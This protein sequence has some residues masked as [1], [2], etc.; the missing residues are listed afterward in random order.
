MARKR[1]DA[2]DLVCR[3]WA[4]QRRK[5]LGLEDALTAREILGAIRCT[6]GE[7]RDLHH[8]SRSGKVEQHWPEVYTGDALRVNLAWWRMRPE[9]KDTLDLHYVARD[10]VEEKAAVIH[11]SVPAYYQRVAAAKG[12]VESWLAREELIQE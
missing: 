6:L 5:L 8:G 1:P 3:E 2:I 7:R 12:F 11:K 9:L 10:S 4:R